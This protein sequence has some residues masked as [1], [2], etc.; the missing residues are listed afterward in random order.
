[1]G[2]A[3]RRGSFDERKRQ[4]IDSEKARIAEADRLED[5][6]REEKRR[7]FQEWWDAL[8]PEQQEAERKLARDRRSR[9]RNNATA[10]IGL[11]TVLAASATMRGR[12]LF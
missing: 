2:Q 1:M 5:L 3:K 9:S 11:A 12:R 7:K 6:A 4:S 8:T 10:F